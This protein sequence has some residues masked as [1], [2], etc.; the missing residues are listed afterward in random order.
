MMASIVT[1]DDEPVDNLFSEKQQRL[2]VESLY[3]NWLHTQFGKRFLAA[4]NVGVFY[5]GYSSPLVP[6]VFLSLD[7]EPYPDVWADEGRSYFIWVYGKPPDVVIEVVSNK[8]GEE[9]S[10]KADAYRQMGV[11]YYVVYDPIHTL[12]ETSL[13][14]LEN[15]FW[16]WR[17]V[18]PHQLQGLELGLTLWRGVYEGLEAEWLRWQDAQGQLVLTGREGIEAERQRAEMER[19][20]AEAERQRAEA[21]EQRVAAIL[22]TL[23]AERQYV[24]QLKARLRE[25]GIEP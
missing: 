9:L 24:E 16:E 3:A 21:A 5:G 15:H 23:E 18:A 8:K 12:S 22:Q 7:V 25:L 10:R 1:E 20:R 11:K 6:D 19:Q 17:L 2:L 14:V 4:A 13:Q